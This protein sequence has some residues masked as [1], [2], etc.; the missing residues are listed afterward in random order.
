MGSAKP[1]ITAPP[2]F[3]VSI[4]N[5]RTYYRLWKICHKITF[6]ASATGEARADCQGG[7][8]IDRIAASLPVRE[9]LVVEALGIRG[10]HSPATGR[11]H[12]TGVELA[13][14]DAQSCKR[15]RRPTSNVDSMMVLRARRG[16]TGFEIRDF[17]GG[18]R[19]AIPFLLV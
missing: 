17:A 9:L 18:L 11:I 13:T 12:G 8:L 19:Q 7:E 1:S 16:S 6:Y 2:R 10:C 5:R 4:D 14:I 3:K 15:K